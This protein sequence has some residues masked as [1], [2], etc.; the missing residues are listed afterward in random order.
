ML[1]HLLF[2]FILF[3]S[4]A[5]QLHAQISLTPTS[6]TA[7]ITSKLQGTGVTISN[8]VIGG[9]PLLTTAI[10]VFTG[11]QTNMSNPNIKIASGILLT[12]GLAT[13]ING[14]TNAIKGPNNHAT[15]T[16]TGDDA[17]F[18]DNDLAVI[19]SL[20][21]YDVKIL[22]FDIIPNSNVL[23]GTF[24]FGSEEYPVYV[25]SEYNDA[26]A[27]IIDG[28]GIISNGAYSDLDANPLTASRN[29]AV[30]PYGNPIAINEINGGVAGGSADGTPF[31][32][33]NTAFYIRN[34]PNTGDATADGSGGVNAATQFANLQSNGFTTPLTFRVPVIA[35]QT[36]KIKIVIGDIGDGSLDSGLFLDVFSSVPADFGDL[37]SSYTTLSQD[38]ISPTGSIVLQQSASHIIAIPGNLYIGSAAPDGEFNGQPDN[39]AE[40]DLGDE[41]GVTTSVLTDNSTSLTVTVPYVNST[42]GSVNLAGWV[43][44]NR[45]DS[46]ETSEGVIS[47]VPAGSGNATLIFTNGLPVSQSGNYF[48]RLR[49]SSA[50]IT[51]A[52]F[53]GVLPDGEVEDYAVTLTTVLPLQLISFNALKMEKAAW[54]KWVTTVEKSTS[55]FVVQRSVDN[56]VWSDKNNIPAAGNS[57][58]E[59]NYS[60][61]DMNPAMGLNFYRLKMVDINGS[62]TYSEIRSLDFSNKK[63][64]ITIFPNPAHNRTMLL[65]NESSLYPVS[66]RIFSNTGMLLQRH[67]L[68]AGIKQYELRVDALSAGVYLVEVKGNEV[69]IKLKLLV[70]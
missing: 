53:A 35:G 11:G 44:W 1:K 66:V 10:A 69:D 14:S 15:A 27:I 23:S 49:I 28:P 2:T 22:T 68:K 41:G 26:S 61:K 51:T 37:P 62:A 60:A 31:S 34:Y 33:S 58:I 29:L 70:Q 39:N 65:F 40:G 64:R 38:N 20:G 52:D 8:L 54:L 56:A 36:Y 19:N 55:H 30:L 3:F 32:T 59:I 46:F 50:S 24:V 16:F 48:M 21:S 43:D 42:G 13:D 7:T 5:R 12:T 17:G 45:N 25:G 6:N 57:S 18:A 47:T 63:E 4:A 9:D 67:I